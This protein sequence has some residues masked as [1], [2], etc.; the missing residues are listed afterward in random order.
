MILKFGRFQV[1]PHCREAFAEGM[2]VPNDCG[3]KPLRLR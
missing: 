2:P 3:A 1:L